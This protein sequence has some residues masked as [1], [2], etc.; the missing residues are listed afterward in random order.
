MLSVAAEAAAEGVVV[1]VEPEELSLA[2]GQPLEAVIR[3]RP[4]RRVL[5]GRKIDRRLTLSVVSDGGALATVRTEYPDDPSLVNELIRSARVLAVLLV[6]L[7]FGGIALLR[8]ETTSGTVD[9]RPGSGPVELPSAAPTTELPSET[10]QPGAGA[11]TTETPSAGTA[12]PGALP[13]PGPAPV[14]PRLVFV[15]VYGPNSRDLVVRQPGDRES[16]LRLRSDNAVELRPRLSPSGA[17]VAFV[18]ERDGAWRVCVSPST[19]GEAVCVADTTSDA[20][21]AWSADGGTLLFSRSG[22]LRSVAYDIGSQTA[23]PEVDLGVAV[24]GG[25]FSLSRDGSRIVV[26]DGRKLLIRPVD[27]SPGV[28]VDV[29]RSVADPSFSPDGSRI[30][31]TADFQIFTVG[32]GGGAVRQLTRPNTVNGEPTW[33]GAGD[34]VVFRSNRSGSGDLYVVKAS[35]ANGEETGLARLTTS[36]ERDAFPS[37]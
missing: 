34:W 30:V 10:T 6:I 24:P 9:V 27:G 12:E 15:R 36:N 1:E 21:V 33:T 23:G 19:G 8:S 28:T 5:P 37:F 22:A 13:E 32:V 31:F 2:P 20:A 4:P 25:S 14:L 16:E 29:S 18:R 7:F 3:V 26:A 11:A 35:A 17:D